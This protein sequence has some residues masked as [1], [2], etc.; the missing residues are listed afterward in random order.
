MKRIPVMLAVVVLLA[1]SVV[2]IAEDATVLK[3]EREKLSYGLGVEMGNN[4]KR[5][6]VDIDAA[7]LTQG[8][9][10]ALTGGQLLLGEAECREAVMAFQKELMAKQQEA[11][12]VRSEKAKAEGDAFLLANAKKEGVTTLPSGL[13]YKVITPG[14]GPFPKATDTVTVHYRGR[15]VDG[16][17][18][19][20]SYKRNEP[21]S[22]PVNGVIAG[23]TEALQLMKVGSKWELYIPAKIAYGD[24]G[25][26][27][28]IPPGATLIFEVEL[29]SIK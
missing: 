2:A 21:T 15:L 10:D 1:T 19:D 28:V 11:Q 22:F 25:A 4:L 29:L 18:F 14:S 24:R 5:Q 27:S 7:L 8:L 16:T 13:Q 12:K 23:W 17:E 26:G 3:S 20:S 9:R 6:G